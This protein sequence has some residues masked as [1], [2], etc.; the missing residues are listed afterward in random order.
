MVCIDKITVDVYIQLG[1]QEVK[2]ISVNNI[3]VEQEKFDFG[4]E[5]SIYKLQGRKRLYKEWFIRKNNDEKS[6]KII[7]NKVNK[8]EIL[9]TKK[10]L[11]KYMVKPKE[12]VI[13]SNYYTGYIMDC[14]DGEKLERY[15]NYKDTVILLK[16]IK[17]AL[18]ELEKNGVMYFDLN[19]SNIL[20]KKENEELDFR[21]IDI[22]NS[23]VEDRDMDFLPPFIRKYKL[24]GGNLD[25]NAL[26]YA[27][28]HLTVT[29]LSRF[30]SRLTQN[31]Y[32]GTYN[33]LIAKFATLVDKPIID[34]IIDNEYLIDHYNENQ[35]F[36]SPLL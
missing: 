28:N 26:I 7:S 18:L 17:E 35:T 27:Y 9:E 29:L 8:L 22:D 36:K 31:P 6:H 25:K 5:S 1:V 3:K 12:L 4:D 16:K 32:I 33:R 19:R 14:Y 24:K 2:K 21:I 15:L 34:S 23:K 13:D 30:D 20:Y 11:F 10:D